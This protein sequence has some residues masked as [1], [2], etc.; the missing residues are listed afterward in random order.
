MPTIY[1]LCHPN[2]TLEDN[3]LN[4]QQRQKKTNPIEE[5]EM[6]TPQPLSDEIWGACILMSFK[7]RPYSQSL[8]EKGTL[9][10]TP[11]LLTRI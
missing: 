8:M 1:N 5:K 4:L 6:M 7:N 2:Q 3:V 10:N 9:E 11:P